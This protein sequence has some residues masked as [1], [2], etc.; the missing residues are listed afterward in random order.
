MNEIINQLKT[1]RNLLILILILTFISAKVEVKL[2]RKQ[3]EILIEN[4]KEIKINNEK[5]DNKKKD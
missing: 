1:I 2:L 4:S 5:L 3:N